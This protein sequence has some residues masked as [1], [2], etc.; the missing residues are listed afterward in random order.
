[1]KNE[2]SGDTLV[3]LSFSPVVLTVTGGVTVL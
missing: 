3:P 1:M 2:E